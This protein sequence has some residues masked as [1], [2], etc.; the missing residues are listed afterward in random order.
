MGSIPPPPKRTEPKPPNARP[1]HSAQVIERNH[2]LFR[3]SHS[4]SPMFPCAFCLA[5]PGSHLPLF[6]FFFHQPLGSK[7]I[8]VTIFNNITDIIIPYHIAFIFPSHCF[9]ITHINFMSLIRSVVGR[10]WQEP[11]NACPFFAF[12]H[13]ISQV[14]MSFV[15]PQLLSNCTSS[16][17]VE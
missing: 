9:S 5:L 4:T 14:M 7:Y 2:I 12:G 11:G 3:F 17:L 6:R 8:Q 15:P 1:T 13:S 16:V 10:T